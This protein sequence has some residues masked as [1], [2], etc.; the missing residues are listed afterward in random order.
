MKKTVKNSSA[1]TAFAEIVNLIHSARRQAFQA[2]NTTLIELYWQV[3]AHISRK[4]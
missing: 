4:L 2:V 3:G 1:E